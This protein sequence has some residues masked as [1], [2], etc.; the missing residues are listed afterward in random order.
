[1]LEKRI[2]DL[3]DQAAEFR[4]R[5]AEA[6]NRGD[7]DAPLPPTELVRPSQGRVVATRL[8]GLIVRNPGGDR[9]AALRRN[10]RGG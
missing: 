9:L 8:P 2:L 4:R 1:M 3:H 5:H 7:K 6:V 10:Q